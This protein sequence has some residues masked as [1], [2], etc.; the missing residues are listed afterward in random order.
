MIVGQDWGG[1]QGVGAALTRVYRLKALVLMNTWCYT[2]HLGQFHQS[3]WPW[4][5]WHAPLFGQF[6]HK[7]MKVLSQRGPSAVS[8]R[9]MTEEEAR[10][11]HHVFE[12]PDSDHV[13]L[14]WPRTIPLRKGD[15]GWADMQL[16][17]DRLGELR[18]IPVLLLWAPGDVVFDIS[19]AHH[20]KKLFPQAEGPFEFDRAAHF[21]QDDR[22]PDLV[23]EIVRFLDKPSCPQGRDTMNYEN[24][25]R[26]GE[27]RT[28]F[29]NYT[30]K[31]PGLRGGIEMQFIQ[32]DPKELEF[33]R[34]D[35]LLWEQELDVRPEQAEALEKALGLRAGK[36]Y[37]RSEHDYLYALELADLGRGRP[38]MATLFGYWDRWEPRPPE[39]EINQDILSFLLWMTEFS[40]GIDAGTVEKLARHRDMPKMLEWPKGSVLRTPEERFANLPDFPYE[41]KY[42]EME[43]LRMAYVEAG[44]GDPIW[45]QHGEPT[46]GF[47]YRH[48]I[49]I[50]AETGR[51]IVPDL[52][53][54]GRS[55]K[56]TQ[57]NAYSYKSHVRWM[58]NF[59][60]ILDLKNITLV[61]QDWGG[62]I[63]LRVLSERPERF[64]RLVAMNTG[65]TP[66]VKS[67]KAF[68]DWLRTSQSLKEMA[69][70]QMM[71]I[72]VNRPLSDAEAAAY[73][74]PFSLQ[75]IPDLRPSFS[76]SGSHQTGPTRFL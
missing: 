30:E 38:S 56:P 44:S 3:P 64:K 70:D 72:S 40:E 8:Q 4:T 24:K 34:P 62:M 52:I 28:L 61:C 53:G 63:G 9:G 26:R 76:T 31:T 71:R 69:V 32:P 60:E 27:P 68:S 20:L 55:D 50:L 66:G 75:G 45:M 65:I 17:E 67:H 49:P 1:P 6:F 25:A 48:M 15:R 51:V 11:Y 57:M 47:L 5:T 29:S 2:S 18:D 42:V 13:V 16:I 74:A 46:W 73:Q 23:R 35:P 39:H 54:F 43:G 37:W 58:R 33:L 36:V 19:Y 22:G 14:T 59:I 7:K 10:A 41:P 21:L 12:E